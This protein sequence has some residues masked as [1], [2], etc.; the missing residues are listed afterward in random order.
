LFLSVAPSG[1]HR[2][3]RIEQGFRFAPP[4]PVV[5]RP[6]GACCVSVAPPLLLRRA[7]PPPPPRR[8]SNTATA[9]FRL[10]CC[11]E[12]TQ[13]IIDIS[14]N[15][16]DIFK[17]STDISTNIIDILSLVRTPSD[18]VLRRRWVFIAPPLCFDRG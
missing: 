2:P 10:S 11:A 13:N 18:F 6:F 17:N 12:Q 15:S 5:C 9:R 14:D 16:I 4:L 7:A 8:T 1:L 3:L